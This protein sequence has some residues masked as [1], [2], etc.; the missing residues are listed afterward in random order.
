MNPPAKDPTAERIAA[1]ILAIFFGLFGWFTLGQGGISLK[2]KSGAT[3]FVSGWAGVAVAALAFM[4]AIFGVTLF[5]RSLK[6]SRPTYYYSWAI[7]LL[8]PLAYVLLRL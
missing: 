1:S 7:V 2:G 3:S 4:V 6:S 8:P 5:L